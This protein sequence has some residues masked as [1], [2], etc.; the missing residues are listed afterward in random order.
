MDEILLMSRN[1]FEAI[2]SALSYV[3]HNQPVLLDHFWE[4]RWLIDAWNQ[5]MA[6]NFLALLDQ[7]D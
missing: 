1:R 7:C 3:D 4:V 6:E 5:N 2:L